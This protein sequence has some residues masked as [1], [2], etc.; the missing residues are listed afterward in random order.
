MAPGKKGYSLPSTWAMPEPSMQ[1]MASVAA[2]WVWL[3]TLQPGSHS[4]MCTE[5]AQ[6]EITGSSPMKIGVIYRPKGAGTWM[7]FFLSKV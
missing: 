7:E 4:V 5:K 1:Y 2:S 6:S 3:S